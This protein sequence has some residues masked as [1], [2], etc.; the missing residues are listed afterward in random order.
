MLS[1]DVPS[2][3]L[4]CVASLL[5]V[6]LKSPPLVT[7]GSSSG[8]PEVTLVKGRSWLHFV[9][10]G[11]NV[12]TFHKYVVTLYSIGANMEMRKCVL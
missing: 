9:N 5:R 4:H 12:K 7:L 3:Y 10:G 1:V 11:I 2:V 8:D 6:T